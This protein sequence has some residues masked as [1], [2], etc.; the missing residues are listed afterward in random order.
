VSD[1]EY[2]NFDVEQAAASNA[3]VPAGVVTAQYFHPDGTPKEMPD[4]IVAL[5][6][7]LGQLEAEEE[8]AA[9]MISPTTDYD[10][11]WHGHPGV[12][13]LDDQAQREAQMAVS[14][15]AYGQALLDHVRRIGAGREFGIRDQDALERVAGRVEEARQELFKGWMADGATTAQALQALRDLDV[16]GGV[17]V[18]LQEEKY[19]AV[20]AQTKVGAWRRQ[21]AQQDQ[22]LASVGLPA[23]R[24]IAEQ[25]PT[26]QRMRAAAEARNERITAQRN[27]FRQRGWA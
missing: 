5:E 6:A 16:T 23:R 9:G 19:R 1:L 27:Y 26:L 11:V 13:E 15:E 24:S 25:S 10:D 8:A 22:V 12:A 17:R 3:G 21:Q 7:Y 18:L 14:A 2:D 4:G 20:T